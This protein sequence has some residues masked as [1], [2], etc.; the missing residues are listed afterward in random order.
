MSSWLWHHRSHSPGRLLRG[1]LPT[2]RHMGWRW[3]LRAAHGRRL[4]TLL[5][6]LLERL[7]HAGLNLLLKGLLHAGLNLLLKG[8]L[9][10]GHWHIIRGTRLPR[11]L[12]THG[13]SIRH[14]WN[15]GPWH[16]AGHGIGVGAAWLASFAFLVCRLFPLLKRHAFFT[17]FGGLCHYQDNQQHDHTEYDTEKTP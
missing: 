9:H 12:H 10:A 4:H 2:L 3:I 13:H 14:A 6:L 8:L 15:S 7:L 5:E 16:T 11:T 1:L 17:R